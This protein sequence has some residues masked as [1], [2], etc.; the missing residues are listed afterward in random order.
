MQAWANAL[1]RSAPSRPDPFDA[2]GHY[3]TATITGETRLQA[4][5]GA[6]DEALAAALAHPLFGSLSVSQDL[7]RSI[8]RLARQGDHTVAAAAQALAANPAAAV[9]A[10]GVLAKLDLLRA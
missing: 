8:F 3:A 1:A 9:R 7:L 10:A 2:F 4:A 5:P 6:T